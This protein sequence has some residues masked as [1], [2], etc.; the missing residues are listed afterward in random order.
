MSKID[1]T[2][3]FGE[4]REKVHPR[5]FSIWIWLLKE[6]YNINKSNRNAGL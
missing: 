1:V 5:Q 4:K 2:N 6:S 3:E